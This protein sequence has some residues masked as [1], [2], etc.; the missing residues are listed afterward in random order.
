METKV[1]KRKKIIVPG[2]SGIVRPRTKAQPAKKRVMKV[3]QLDLK[4]IRRPQRKLIEYWPDLY[5][6]GRI[7][8]VAVGIREAMLADLQ[9]R[10]IIINPKRLE[11]ELFNA[12]NTENYQ[13]RILFMKH[14]HG[15]DGKP[16]AEITD[17]ERE[18]AYQKLS[19]RMT[20]RGRIPPRPGFWKVKKAFH[21]NLKG[22]KPVNSASSS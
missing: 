13:R 20:E 4:D 1:I 16:V 7:L 3:K 22:P 17:T 9:A 19:A 8:P 10:G 6:N 12:L 2:E 5:R 11:R 15:L 14:R 18:Y 21:K